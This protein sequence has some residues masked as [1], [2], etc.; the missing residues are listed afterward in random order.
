MILSLAP[1][2]DGICVTRFALL[3]EVFV[4]VDV[5]INDIY[6]QAYSE[7]EPTCV[8]GHLRYTVV[9]R[10]FAMINLLFAFGLLVTICH[11]TAERM[12]SFDWYIFSYRLMGQDIICLTTLMVPIT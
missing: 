7:Y 10:S 11:R 2:P 8:R 1:L 4:L 5:G 6:E 3:I 12:Q 9:Y